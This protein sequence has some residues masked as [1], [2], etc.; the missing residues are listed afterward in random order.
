VCPLQAYTGRWVWKTIGDSLLK[1]CYPS[2]DDHDRKIRSRKQYT[3]VGM[4][5][6]VNRTTKGWNLLPTGVLASYP[7]N[8]IAF[9]K[10]AKEVVTPQKQQNNHGIHLFQ[11]RYQRSQIGL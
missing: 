2:R 8:I 5:S 3:D 6:F 7:C 4:H 1:L 9:R 10:R 11:Y